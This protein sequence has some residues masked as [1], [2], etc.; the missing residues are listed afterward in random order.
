[1]SN[2]QALHIK[3]AIPKDGLEIINLYIVA[4]DGGLIIS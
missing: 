4:P 1:M 3:K 2:M